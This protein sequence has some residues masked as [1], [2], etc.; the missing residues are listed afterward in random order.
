MLKKNVKIC[1]FLIMFAILR[2][3]QNLFKKIQLKFQL[4][5]YQKNKIQ[6]QN[7]KE[8][9]KSKT[10]YNPQNQIFSFFKKKKKGFHKKIIINRN[11]SEYE[12]ST[13]ISLSL[14]NFQV[15]GFMV[16]KVAQKYCVLLLYI[17]NP[18]HN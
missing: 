2:V 15:V 14:F 3:L 4:K 17:Q 5:S 12:Q 6:T 1:P 10:I 16:F 11:V 8:L 7:S 18:L 13:I 9:S